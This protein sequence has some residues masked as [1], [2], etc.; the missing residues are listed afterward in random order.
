MLWR[1]VNF[2]TASRRLRQRGLFRFWDGA[3]WRYADPFKAW[4][5]I[6]NHEKLNLEDMA[7]A[8]DKGD[9]PETSIALEVV[10]QVFG[11]ERWSQQTHRGLTDSELLNLLGDFQEFLEALKKNGNPGPISSPPTASE[12]S[13]GPAV[14][15]AA[16]SFSSA[17]GYA[18]SEPSSASPT[19]P[20]A[21]SV[22]E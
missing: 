17:F 4:R 1:L 12:S 13:T 9:E 16:T 11:V 7:E 14:P 6:C 2:L 20:S 22:P 15:D 3:R 5:E 18:S 10:C 21:A 19:A 8:I